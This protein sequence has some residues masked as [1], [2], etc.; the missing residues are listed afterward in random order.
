MSA[1]T[2]NRDGQRQ[3]AEKTFDTGASGYTYYKE[4]LLMKAPTGAVLQPAVQGAGASNGRFLGVVEDRVDLLAGLGS[5]Q[6]P[7][8]AWKEGEFTFAT[9]GT[10]TSAHIGQRAYALDDQ[11]VGVSM[12]PP[13]LWVGEITAVPTTSTYRVRI[14]GAVGVPMSNLSLGASWAVAQN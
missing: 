10:G 6:A 12:A 9:N 3:P 14:D 1:A 8:N 11:T 5:S 13:A 4:T 7:L 2:T